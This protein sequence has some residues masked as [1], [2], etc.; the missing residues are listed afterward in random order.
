MN[1][2]PILFGGALVPQEPEAPSARKTIRAG[3]K[4]DTPWRFLLGE[5]AWYDL[6]EQLRD[7]QSTIFLGLWC[8]GPMVHALFSDGVPGT[9]A[10]LRPLMAS[11]L[12][13]GPRYRG[14][15]AVRRAASPFERMIR[16]L[17]GVEA[18]DA[19]DARPLVDRGAWS[20]TAPLTERPPPATTTTGM[21]EFPPPDP[22]VAAQG[23]LAT[24]GPATGGPESP[25]HMRLGVAEGRVRTVDTLTGFAH[26]G[27][28]SRMAG[29]TLT[30]A[31]ELAGRISAL[32]AVAHQ[33]A[34]SAAVEK[35]TGTE[36]SPA[37]DHIRALLCEIERI[38][39][40]LT[41]LARTA[42]ATGAD[43]VATRLY[44]ARE[45]LSRVCGATLGRRLLMDCIAPGGVTLA[46]SGGDLLGDSMVLEALAS[47]CDEIA[48]FGA[49]DFPRIRDCW[50]ACAPLSSGLAGKGVVSR[51]LAADLSLSGPVGRAAGRGADVRQAM[52]S[53]S[54]LRIRTPV[55]TDGDAATRNRIRFEDIAESLRMIAA[56]G[57]MLAARSDAPDLNLLAPLSTPMDRREGYAAVEGPHGLICHV[58]ILKDGQVAHSFIAD[59]AAVLQDVQEITLSGCALPEFDGVR[60]SFGVS[61]TAVDL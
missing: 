40:H 50:Q 12:L 36:I 61:A 59:P 18:M 54:A 28:A 60:C 47:L 13:D 22:L 20:V 53:Y 9:E 58:V 4:T 31:T 19:S 51:A 2:P 24:R 37:A 23:M 8:D 42:R 45:T 10:A 16:D 1:I 44:R 48:A 25:I 52:D 56:L 46:L 30:R 41:C 14:F 38:Y 6:V 29:V 39:T 32:S 49:T 5:S 21:P 15:S 3:E 57:D 43:P 35:A 26:R 33:W 7:D 17:W 34:F 11:H 55:A 27:L